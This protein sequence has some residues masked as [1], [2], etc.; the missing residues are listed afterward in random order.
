VRPYLLATAQNLLR[1]RFR[2]P[3][4]VVAE[5]EVAA[6]ATADEGAGPLE[7]AADARRS[8]EQ[9]AVWEEFRAALAGAL[10]GLSADHRRAFELGVVERHTYDEVARLTGWSLAQVKTN[11]H[12]ARKGVLA[13]LGDRL[14]DAAWSLP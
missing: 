4:L 2:R 8:P 1:N 9:A 12:R 5:A 3:R 7:R 11:I 10:A 6:P 13:R 14:P